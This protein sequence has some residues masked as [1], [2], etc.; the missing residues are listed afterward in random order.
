MDNLKTILLTRGQ[1]SN[2]LILED[3][4]PAVEAAFAMY[5]E[6]KAFP[7]QVMGMEVMNGGFHIKAG[8]LNTGR[9]YFVSKVN[10]NFPSNP[11]R[12]GK[13]SIQGIIA[14]MD[15]SDGSLLAL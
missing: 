13:P 12:S 8:I 1:I 11:K 15:A 9:S 2:L 3:C 4:I 5:A 6:G 7:P 10:A 14:V